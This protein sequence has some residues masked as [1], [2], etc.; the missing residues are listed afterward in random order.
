MKLT[1]LVDHIHCPSPQFLLLLLT[2][3]GGGVGTN[4]GSPHLVLNRGG[5]CRVSTGSGLVYLRKIFTLAENTS[6]ATI[7]VVSEAGTVVAGEVAAQL[8]VVDGAGAAVGLR[9]PAPNIFI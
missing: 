2:G 4:T 6:T 9:V 8:V 5:F 1:A 7:P 3:A